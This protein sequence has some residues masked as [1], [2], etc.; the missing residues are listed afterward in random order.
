MVKP[1]AGAGTVRVTAESV[2]ALTCAPAGREKQNTAA[3][4]ISTHTRSVF[5]VPALN[6][7]GC[8]ADNQAYCIR[9]AALKLT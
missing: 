6:G 7:G 3:R 4:T 1:S 2:P 8:P 5:M 9:H